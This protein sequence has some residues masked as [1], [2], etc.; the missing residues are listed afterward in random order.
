[1]TKFCIVFKKFNVAIDFH[2]AVF[3]IEKHSMKSA[4]ITEYIN[5]KVSCSGL[6]KT[7]RF[8]SEQNFLEILIFSN[9][10]LKP[11]FS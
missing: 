4:H 11:R 10:G 3:K 2:S 5:V 8:L 7:V 6:F 1:M 9:N